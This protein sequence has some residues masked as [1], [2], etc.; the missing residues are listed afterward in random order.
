MTCSKISSFDSVLAAMAT[1]E[2]QIAAEPVVT[3]N[4]IANASQML[5]N[6][7][8]RRSVAGDDDFAVGIETFVKCAFSNPAKGILVTGNSGVGK[9]A[10]AKA[11]QGYF[12][13]GNV[14]CLD[15]ANPETLNLIDFQSNPDI[16]LNFCHSTLILDDL[17]AEPTQSNF[18]QPR[19]IAAEFIMRY[20]A[21]RSDKRMF[22][23]TNLTAA[24]L[25]DR[26]QQRIF[27]RMK[28]LILP[29]AFTGKN[30]RGGAA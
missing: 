3:A 2:R 4:R 7:G 22:I 19:E 23:T 1:T 13:K 5:E 24:E 25:V 28:D 30:K 26:Y 9:T 15:L 6:A 11:V 20:H 12:R 14:L 17:G 18:G 8:W 27:T 16:A 29:I 10:Y 21:E